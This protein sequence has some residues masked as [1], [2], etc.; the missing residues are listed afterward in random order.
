MRCTADRKSM[1]FYLGDMV[2]ILIA[3]QYNPRLVDMQLHVC[4][5]QNAINYTAVQ[6]HS[7]YRQ[8]SACGV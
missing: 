7:T 2:G 4:A 5:V 8:W 3:L 1:L 6:Y